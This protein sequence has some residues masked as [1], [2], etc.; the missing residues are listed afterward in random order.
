M[1]GAS[2]SAD[3]IGEPKMSTL[4]R[5]ATRRRGLSFAI[6]ITLMALALLA[7]AAAEA[8]ARHNSVTLVSEPGAYVGGGA[9]HLFASPDLA[10]RGTWERI[11]VTA[12]GGGQSFALEFTPPPGKRLEAGEYLGAEREAHAGSSTPGLVVSGNSTQ[13]NTDYGRFL[14]KSVKYTRAG[15]V[16]GLWALYEQHC[17]R[18]GGGAVFGEVRINQPYAE[19]PETSYPA[20]V[21]WPATPAGTNTYPVPVKIVG[22][23]AGGHVTSVA[24]AGA[25]PGEFNIAKDGCGGSSLPAGGSCE[26][27]LTSRPSLQGVRTARLVVQDASGVQTTVQLSVDAGPQLAINSA[28]LVSARGSFLFGG[29]DKLVDAPR[30]LELRPESTNSQVEVRGESGGHT[31]SFEFAAP[32]GKPLE[33]REYPNAESYGPYPDPLPLISVSG[34][35]TGCSYEYGRFTIKDLHFNAFAKIDRLW[36]V[37][38]VRCP[39]PA[40]PPVFG[41]VRVGESAPEAPEAAIPAAIDW[42]ATAVGARSTEVPVTVV[43]G[44]AGANVAAISI[45]GEDAGDFRIVGDECQNAPLTPGGTCGLKVVARP[46][47][48]GRRTAELVITDASGAHTSVQLSVEGTPPPDPPMASNSATLVS[49]PGDPFG[50]GQDVLIDTPEAVSVGGNASSVEVQ[51]I[52]GG[53][54]YAFKLSPPSGQALQDGE[55]PGAEGEGSEVPGHPHLSVTDGTKA[56]HRS[57]GRFVIKD[58]RFTGAGAADRLWALYE[59]HCENLKEPGLFGEVR[60]GEPP[61]EAPET[62]APLAIEWPPTS[63]SGYTQAVPVT[64]GAGESGAEVASVAIEG[65]EAAEFAIASNTCPNTELAP[66]ARCEVSVV[67][68]PSAAG[69][70]TAQLTIKDR[71]GAITTVPLSATATGSPD[72]AAEE[73]VELAFATAEKFGTQH[74]G[75]YSGLSPRALQEAEPAI[76]IEGNGHRT[77]L[78][79]AFALESGEAFSVTATAVSGHTFTITRLRNGGVERS[80]TPVGRTGESAGAC[81]NSTW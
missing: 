74:G 51:A 33:L 70:H 23:P 66:L 69:R 57:F 45:Q 72:G 60:V 39:G 58:I 5:R 31:L 76:P 27:V 63:V 61:T 20:A 62:V 15:R 21:E 19:A 8:A 59:L 36:A 1:D 2:P 14:I 56:C 53:E 29:T 28:A 11:E 71:S 35:E 44:E 12:K 17:E 41:E 43:G 34:G 30:A 55:Y 16:L 3:E 42:P 32:E 47:A 40:S 68:S 64:I 18:T 48:A 52:R 79:S 78:S 24:L 22:G 9:D 65:K 13:C 4:R 80:C 67:A 37:F 10:L 26:V 49:E 7:P 50:G 73:L 77:Y 6:P 38:E 54:T 46:E 81:Q 75:S 25:N